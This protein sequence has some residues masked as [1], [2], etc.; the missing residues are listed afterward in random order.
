[1][2]HSALPVNM[3]NLIWILAYDKHKYNLAFKE[4]FKYPHL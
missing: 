2:L 1:M 4:E 3:C